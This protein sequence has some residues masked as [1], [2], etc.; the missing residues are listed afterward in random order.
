MN[1]VSQIEFKTSM[2]KSSL[3]DYSGVYIL[4]SGTITVFGAGA[5]DAARAEDRNNKQAISKNCTPFTDCITEIN[6]T[7]RQRKRFGCYCAD[8]KTKSK[9]KTS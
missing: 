5:D 6:N 9:S 8:V 1:H 2:L 3:C 4:V 7:S